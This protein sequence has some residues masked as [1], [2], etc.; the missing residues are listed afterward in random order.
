MLSKKTLIHAIWGSKPLMSKPEP[1][2]NKV[3]FRNRQEI[4]KASLKRRAL[5]T[6]R[7]KWTNGT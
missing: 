1:N 5:N 4:L 6:E 7:T 2:F 3:I